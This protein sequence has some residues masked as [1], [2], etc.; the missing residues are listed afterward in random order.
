MTINHKPFRVAL[1]GLGTV[2]SGVVRFLSAH[3]E[4][5]A[6]EAGRK[7]EIAAVCTRNPHKK[8][9][10]AKSDLP[11]DVAWLDDARDLAARNDIDA[12]VELIGGSS[13]IAHD[14]SRQTLIQ[15][16]HLITANKALL[17]EKGADL[18]QLARKNNCKIAYEA[19]VAGGIP[20]IASLRD[21]LVAN[22]IR[23]V[24]GIING[25]CNLILSRM[26][27]KPQPI[28]ELICQAQEQGF[29]ESSPE[30]DVDGF[31]SAH[32]IA[33]I[34][35]LVFDQTIPYD[36]IHI[37]GICSIT[38]DD[39][40]Y[41]KT[42]GYVIKLIG[43][44]SMRED[45]KIMIAVMPTLVPLGNLLASVGGVTNCVSVEADPSGSFHFIGAGAGGDPTAS[46]VV[47]DMIHLARHYGA[48]H[49][50]EGQK[51]PPL[52]AE[53]APARIAGI[54]E[55]Q[56]Q[57]YLRLRVPDTYGVI[58]KIT[59]VLARY[60]ISIDSFVQYGNEKPLVHLILIT[61]PTSYQQISQTLADLH[62]L[63]SPL[64]PS[65]KLI[66]DSQFLSI[67]NTPNPETSS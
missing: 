42:L 51:S 47:A 2:G 13:G 28:Q 56:S 50:E 43:T 9:S 46:A 48:R 3:Q 54:H 39:I 29:A 12:V 63:P 67:L 44:T 8:R 38:T 23:K 52:P 55:W 10:F 34:A 40:H 61:H 5:I 36:Q 11:N 21:S 25:T 30:A 49:Y 62:T 60:A 59:E 17:A 53:P 33:L 37:E 19:A 14:I 24:H 45:G 1:A 41:A 35:Q 32:K 31:D 22:Q 16:K 57:F 7:I 64:N 65:E 20:I 15:Q 26:H 27:E 58:A 18:W 4:K 6:K 66:S